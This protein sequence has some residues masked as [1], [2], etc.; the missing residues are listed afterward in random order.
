MTAQPMTTVPPH[1]A[2]T[3]SLMHWNDAEILITQGKSRLVINDAH[4]GHVESDHII[5]WVHTL[6]LSPVA[7]LHLCAALGEALAQYQARYGP[8]AHDRALA[9]RIVGLP[10][11]KAN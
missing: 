5:E 8:I 7:A 1:L 11:G 2:V 4:A 3:H 9:Q 10:D 6:S